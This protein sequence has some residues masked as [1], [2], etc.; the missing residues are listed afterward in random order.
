MSR[1]AAHTGF[2]ERMDEKRSEPRLMC[3]DLVIVFWREGE[4]AG[5]QEAGVLEN[6]SVSGA[7]VQCEIPVP[8]NSRVRLACGKSEFR[9][10]VRFCYW[11]DHGYFIGI[12]FD[13]DSK[14]SVAKFTPKHLL[15]PREVKPRRAG[16]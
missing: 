7:C 16:S 4:N 13:A 2:K 14:W 12:A 3:A 11:R 6:I 8:K 15:D 10:S 5:R 9:G 1:P